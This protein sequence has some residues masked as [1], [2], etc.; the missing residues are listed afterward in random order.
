MATS[1]LAQS[2]YLEVMHM[3]FIHILLA[4]ASQVALPHL[5]RAGKCGPL[6]CQMERIVAMIFHD[7]SSYCCIY[8][9]AY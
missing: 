2:Y 6:L 5:E 3:T 1:T 4:A 8:N 9:V 7:I